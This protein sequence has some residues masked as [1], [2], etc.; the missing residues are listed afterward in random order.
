MNLFFSFWQSWATLLK[1]DH[2]CKIEDNYDKAKVP[3][4]APLILDSW[5]FIYDVTDVNEV[6]NS[7]TIYMWLSFYWT[8]PGLSYKKKSM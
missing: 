3:G 4:I 2:I 6:D 1:G 5:I 8:D 7:I